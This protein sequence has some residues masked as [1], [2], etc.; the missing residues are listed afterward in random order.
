MAKRP[1]RPGP[2][3]VEAW[4]YGVINPLTEALERESTLAGLKTPTFRWRTHSLERILPIRDYLSRGGV[5]ILE[6]LLR[7]ERSVSR[8]EREHD[9]VVERLRA[10]A[11]QLFQALTEDPVFR[12]FS[13]RGFSKYA[14]NP[15]T[16]VQE[17]AEGAVNDVPAIVNARP[18]TWAFAWNENLVQ[19]HV[20]RAEAGYPAL[21]KALAALHHASEKSNAAFE[22]LR[23]E[24]VEAFDVPPAPLSQ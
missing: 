11:T 8:I 15:E 6:D 3:R 5:L 17:V 10:T 7:Y 18:G 1:A 16:L 9:E 2:R 4:L 19:T 22:K 24:L 12:E 23:V 20:A 13:K 21:E 14:E